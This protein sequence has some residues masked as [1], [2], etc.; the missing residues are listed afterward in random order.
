MSP[1]V[2][3]IVTRYEINMNTLKLITGLIFFTVGELRRLVHSRFIT[4]DDARQK[5]VTFN[6]ISILA[7]LSGWTIFLG[8]I[9]TLSD[10]P[11]FHGQYPTVSCES[12]NCNSNSFSVIGPSAVRLSIF[13][14]LKHYF[15][16]V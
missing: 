13:G 10:S 15:L 9:W 14:L 3:I 6:S 12:L 7:S 8:P 1:T 16:A 5:G 2:A 11:N 4:C